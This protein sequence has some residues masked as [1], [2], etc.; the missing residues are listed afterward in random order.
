[1]LKKEAMTRRK[2]MSEAEFQKVNREKGLN[3]QGLKKWKVHPVDDSKGKNHYD[4]DY[5][6]KAGTDEIQFEAAA[7]EEEKKDKKDKKEKKEQ[8]EE[9]SK[10]VSLNV[11]PSPLKKEKSDT[12]T[13]F[14]I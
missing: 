11:A 7:M 12:D 14:S 8:Q 9:A 1:L 4:R 5:R 3:E 10:D 6:R 13:D 2:T